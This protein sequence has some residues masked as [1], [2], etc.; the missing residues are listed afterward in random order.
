MIEFLKTWAN[1]IIVAVIIATIL[2]MLLPDG[3]N[4]KYIKLVI[5]IYVLFCIIGPIITKVT[6]TNID[7]SKFNYEK[8]FDREIVQTTSQDFESNNSK[9]IKQAYID[10]IKSD[11][12]TKLNK[13]GYEIISL[14]IEI[15]EDENKDTYGAIQN[16]SLEVEK[17]ENKEKNKK[18]S[19]RT[20]TIKIENVDINV[21]NN[22]TNNES[23]TVKEKTNISDN[24]KIEIIEYLSDEYSID[25]K[26]IVIN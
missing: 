15:I 16:L 1:Q 21:N 20:N 10:K 11:I 19:T 24:E 4:K 18:E 9:L 6:G 8:Y 17:L 23:N 14:D 12:T 26:S 3:K 25:K 13:K 7:I 5:G 22:M 2:E